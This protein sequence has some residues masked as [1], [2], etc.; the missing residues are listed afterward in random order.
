MSH[1]SIQPLDLKSYH[2][3]SLLDIINFLQ[4]SWKNL[5]I[6]SIAGAILG[7]SGW[8]FL[9]SYSAEYV[10]IN[11][12]RT[13][14]S[15]S[16]GLDLLS[17]KSIQKR[18]PSLAAKIIESGKLPEGQTGLYRTLASN[19]WW[20]KN[21]TPNY[22]FSK[23]DGLTVDV[24]DTVIS[25]LVFNA[26]GSSKQGT[27]DVVEGAAQFLRSGGAYLQIRD[28]LN[29]YEG[30]II[31]TEGE[32]QQRIASTK[33]DMGYQQRRLKSLEE[34]YRRYP[35]SSNAG[36]QVLDLKDSGAK[37]LSITTQII[38]VNNEFDQSKEILVKMEDRLAQIKLTRA[39]LDDAVP[40]S[41]S[42]LD[43]LDLDKELIALVA[44]MRTKISSDD[45][46]LQIVL[47]RMGLQLSIIQAVFTKGLVAYA[48]PTS[49]G[50]KGLMKLISGGLITAFFSM[51]LV[52]VG[53]KAWM[54]T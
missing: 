21:V 32:T 7:L 27:V 33:I 16:F 34:L 50:K 20:V 46:N 25:S 11:N 35:A 43:G 17:W 10:L 52:L 29:Y 2:E 12:A 1:D 24:A 38:A 39:F 13:K 40:M 51:L 8:F 37:Y 9:G 42:N 15:I 6:A 18:L 19:Q 26:N 5:A 30:E 54:R 3:I 4:E 28:M 41:E 47:D 14:T 53:R 45:F 44:Q 36:I 31:R 23:E 49:T 48:P 22:T